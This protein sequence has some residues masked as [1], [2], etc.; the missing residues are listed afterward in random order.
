MLRKAELARTTF[1]TSRLL[2]FFSEAELAKQI[3]HQRNLWP[4]AILKELVDNAL[5]ACESA[6]VKVPKIKAEIGDDFFSV[7]DNG[8]GILPETI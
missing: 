4:I 8:P 6:G 3:G 2:E 7:A 5:D 1:T